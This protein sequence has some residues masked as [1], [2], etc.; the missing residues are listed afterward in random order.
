MIVRYNDNHIQDFRSDRAIRVKAENYIRDAEFLDVTIQSV[1]LQARGLTRAIAIS[2][3]FE[4]ITTPAPAPATDGYAK[5]NNYNFTFDKD[6][7]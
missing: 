1:I 7:M 2:Q 4:W 3:G 5:V 6:A